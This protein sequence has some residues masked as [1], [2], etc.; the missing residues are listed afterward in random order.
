[1]RIAGQRDQFLDAALRELGQ[2]LVRKWMPVAHRN[3]H[4]QA[5]FF[6]QR[7][8]LFAGQLE[9]RRFAADE[10]VVRSH[11]RA[12]RARNPARH[13][14]RQRQTPE[15]ANDV[16]IGKQ[17]VEK[18]LDGIERVGPAQ[19]QENDGSITHLRTAA[20]SASTFSMGVSGRMPWPRLKMWPRRPPRSTMARAFCW[21]TSRGPN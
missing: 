7:I 6:R 9:L 19:I 17:V 3:G 5:D 10:L 11:R 15:A 18:R 8:G 20:I 14:L 4:R 16:A 21:T 13:E 12:A 1:M 2:R